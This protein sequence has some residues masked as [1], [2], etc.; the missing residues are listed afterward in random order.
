VFTPD[1]RRIAY[2]AG[3]GQTHQ[4]YIAGLDGSNAQPVTPP[5]QTDA[6]PKVNPRSG[7]SIVFTSGRSGPQQ[8]YT[9]NT[10]GSDLVRLTN[11]TGEASNPAWHPDGQH[12]A[13]AWTRGYSPGKYN[14][15]VMNV[16]SREY[17]QLTQGEGVNEN[18][19]WSPGGT[20]IVFG[21]KR[22]G[23][24]QIWTMRVDGSDLRQLT[25]TGNNTNPTW[26]RRP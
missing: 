10:D 12:V 21:S 24:Y 7:A 26:A 14:I 17:L 13:F 19:C 16:A 2:M 20:H 1:G 22:S 18:P 8:I 11:G 15:F 4:I 9:V 6:E 25:S 23:S 3:S 5:G